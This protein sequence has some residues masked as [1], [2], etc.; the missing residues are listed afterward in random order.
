MLRLT[1]ENRREYPS[2]RDQLFFFSVEIFKIEIFWSRF[3]FVKIF[4]EIV[5]TNQDFRDF[6]RFLYII[7]TFSRLQAQKSRQIEKSWW[8]T[9]ITL[10]NSWSRSRQTVEICQKCHVSTDFSLSIETFWTCRDKIE[11]SRSQ[12]RYLDRRDSLFETVEIFSAVKTDFFFVS[13]SR[14]SIES[15]DRESRSRPRRDKSRPPTLV[16]SLKKN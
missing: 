16:G 13:R 12:S 8:R 15:L 14:V 7:E 10:T 4:I 2:R 5:E 1:F 3:I 6:S 11:I 9:V